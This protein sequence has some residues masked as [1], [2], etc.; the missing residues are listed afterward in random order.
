MQRSS[1]DFD[2]CNKFL[3]ASYWQEAAAFLFFLLLAW[4]FMTGV[5]QPVTVFYGVI[6]CAFIGGAMGARARANQYRW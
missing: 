5:S 6:M 2:K 4:A 1:G 3:I